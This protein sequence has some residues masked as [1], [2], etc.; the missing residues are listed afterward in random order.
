MPAD[1]SAGASIGRAIYRDPSA[2]P[3]KWVDEGLPEPAVRKATTA[4][5]SAVC[6]V[7]TR[8]AELRRQDGIVGHGRTPT[9]VYPTEKRP[10]VIPATRPC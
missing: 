8:P 10:Q 5:V 2:L 7:L 1:S 6:P 3:A 9:M 4:L